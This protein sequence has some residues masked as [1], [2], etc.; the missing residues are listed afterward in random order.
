MSTA[1]SSADQSGDKLALLRRHIQSLER[2]GAS[3]QAGNLPLDI[4]VLDAALPDGGLPLGALHSFA[5]GDDADLPQILR[6]TPVLGFTAWLAG[7]IIRSRQKA[8]RALWITPE[9]MLYAPA[10][11]GLNMPFER[12]TVLH[13]RDERDRL[14]VCEQA[15]QSGALAVVIA[16]ID[17]L[18]AVSARRLQLAAESSGATVLAVLRKEQPG[19]TGGS[20]FWR[21]APA[22]DEAWRVDLCR[23][24]AGRPASALCGPQFVDNE[25]SDPS[26]FQR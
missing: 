5:P 14:W 9:R 4:A 17:R 1:S 16:E 23:A 6:L 24:R 18:S 26:S 13:S 10:L 20:T 12:L 2:S 21:I 7:K 22:A 8:G 19:P 3:L 11:A 25:P 15:L